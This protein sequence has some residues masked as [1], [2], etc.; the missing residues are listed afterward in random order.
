MGCL[1]AGEV[2]MVDG[3]QEEMTAEQ[4]VKGGKGGKMREEHWT[5]QI[6]CV[7]AANKLGLHLAHLVDCCALVPQC[8]PNQ[9]N[10]AT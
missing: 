9:G 6:A 3:G 1:A 4:E 8:S 10:L 7:G 2:E 5:A